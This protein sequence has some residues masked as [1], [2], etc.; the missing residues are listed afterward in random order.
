MSTGQQ[1]EVD[2]RDMVVVHTA[3]RREFG[4][5]PG[6]VRGVSD[7]DLRRAAVVA[8]HLDLLTTMLHHHHAT[9][10]RL[11][12]PALHQRVPAE[13]DATISLMERQ[14]ERIHAGND[15]VAKRLPTWRAT[16]LAEAGEAL[17][18][19]LEEV[20]A[21]LTEHLAAEEELL[22]PIAARHLTREE[23]LRLGEEGMA[24]LKGSQLPL[25]FG[26]LQYQ[27]DPE[28]VA[29]MLSHA[30]ALARLLMPVMA[31][32]AFARYSRRVHGTAT[33]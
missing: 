4:L 31:P 19:A 2:T 26:M 8:D 25:A 17:A 9:E 13:L 18:E 3:F 28:V 14:H 5:A 11:L 10:D 32:R 12:W 7:G 6:L 30:P 21:A 23:W 33:P 15:A 20:D 24:G 16:A 27:G 1:D 29:E 22:L